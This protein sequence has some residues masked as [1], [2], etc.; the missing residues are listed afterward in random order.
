MK[1]KDSSAIFKIILVTVSMFQST[2]GDCKVKHGERTCDE[3]ESWSD[4]NELVIEN[5]SVRLRKP[6]LNI[7]P[8]APIVLTS[9][10]DIE[11]LIEHFKLKKKSKNH[12]TLNMMGI[13]GIDVIPWSNE[14]GFVDTL[15]AIVFLKI[16]KLNFS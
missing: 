13:G 3:F 12:L 15:Y 4:L 1:N 6:F 8:I 14:T 10:L 2:C 9:E 7:H 5:D 16:L 11:A